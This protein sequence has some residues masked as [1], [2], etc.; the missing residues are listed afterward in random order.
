MLAD[1]AV[2][3]SARTPRFAGYHLVATSPGVT[4]DEARELAAWGP[5]H[6]ALAGGAA[7]ASVQ[8]HP[9]ASGRYCVGRTW[10]AGTEYSGRGQ[11][12]YTQSLL[13]SP[14]TLER[15]GGNALA[16][17]Q[18]ADNDGLFAALE[19][20]PARLPPLPLSGSSPTVDEVELAQAVGEVGG[21][22]LAR[23][24]DALLS[25]PQLAV[26]AG[27]RAQA[28]V[29][30]L[31][32]CLPAEVRSEVT[33]ATGLKFSPRRPYRMLLLPADF[34]DVR[35]IERQ[36]GVHVIDPF[37]E[38]RGFEHPWALLASWALGHG[39]MLAWSRLLS[40]PRPGLRLAD[41]EHLA[42]ELQGQLAP[43]GRLDREHGSASDLAPVV[44]RKSSLLAPH[45]TGR[46]E[47]RSAVE[48]L[49]A[50]ALDAEPRAQQHLWKLWQSATET[51]DDVAVAEL[52]AQL[53]ADV[54]AQWRHAPAGS[55]PQAHHRA[56]TALH[57]VERLL[58][59]G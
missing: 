47:D 21:D 26:A 56:L 40:Q 17:F 13:V 46:Q 52:R 38:R 6:D 29:T 3:T 2:Y 12:V 49:L 20:F 23:L 39:R 8:A 32:N 59:N 10:V 27:D 31:L 24:L 14:E 57:I 42:G 11:R 18:A 33:F 54:L 48:E 34:P 51:A 25:L 53:V 43:R 58:A 15:F 44:P 4:D 45:R 5:S 9:L 55:A 35:R 36:F 19:R 30:G 41:L 28:L 37:D 7:G 1:Q 50:A 22:C 16:L